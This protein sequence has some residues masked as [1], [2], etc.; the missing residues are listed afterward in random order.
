[1]T[2]NDNSSTMYDLVPAAASLNKVPGFDPLKLMR[3]VE[4][5]STGEKAMVLDLQ[6]K[7]LWFRLAYP[8]GKIKLNRQ[9]ISESLAVFEALIYFDRNDLE[10]VSS[11]TVSCTHDDVHNIQAAQNKAIDR[12][13]TDAGFGIQFVK[14]PTSTN[15]S[16]NEQDI[17]GPATPQGINL[18]EAET[19]SVQKTAEIVQFKPEEPMSNFVENSR[20]EKSSGYSE[21]MS[22]EEIIERMTYEEACNVV[23]DTGVCKGMTI[24]QVAEKRAPSLNFY[25][26]SGYKGSNV[27]KAAAQIM[28]NSLQEKKA[29]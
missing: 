17:A 6:Y 18:A 20:E 2:N 4:I 19:K 29:S 21:D 1:M 14:P 22:V 16:R 24:A 26:Y 28:L 25:V 7:K 23:V 5:P 15:Y 10:P 3:T 27:L 9:K 12:A 8:K 11:C 13:L